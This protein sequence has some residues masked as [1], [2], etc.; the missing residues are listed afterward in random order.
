MG[1][2]SLWVWQVAIPTRMRGQETTND[3]IGMNKM[4]ELEV[5]TVDQG[6]HIYVADWEAAVGQIRPCQRERGNIIDP[7]AVPVVESNDTSIDN[8]TPIL[9]EIFVVKT[10][11]NFPETVKFAKVFTCERF[12][13]YSMADGRVMLLFN[14][15]KSIVEEENVEPWLHQ[16]QQ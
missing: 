8:D 4:S 15:D 5:E 12:P 14:P 6:Y 13:L 11:A 9:N 3:W 2:D 16:I 1:N 10:F 7:Y